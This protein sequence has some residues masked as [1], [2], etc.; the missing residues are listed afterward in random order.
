MTAAAEN[1][2]LWNAARAWGWTRLILTAPA[3]TCGPTHR[4]IPREE[5]LRLPSLAWWRVI[6]EQLL[7]IYLFVPRG[8]EVFSVLA[9]LAPGLRAASLG[10]PGHTRARSHTAVSEVSHRHSPRRAAP[11]CSAACATR[12]LGC[13]VRR[14]C[15]GGLENREISC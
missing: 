10:Q 6:P 5:S 12:G 13:A 7:F 14:W 4:W 1:W 2:L 8:T 15:W 9:C 3:G 11:R